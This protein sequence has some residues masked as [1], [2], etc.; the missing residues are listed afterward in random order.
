ML[1]ERLDDA[2][3]ALTGS[4]ERERERETQ[5]HLIDDHTWRD[6]IIQH[7]VDGINSK[8]TG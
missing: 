6:I 1:D 7:D 4:S 2:V 5:F 3:P 8:E